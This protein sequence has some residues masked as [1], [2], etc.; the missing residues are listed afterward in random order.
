M[1]YN[2]VFSKSKEVQPVIVE[3]KQPKILNEPV[4]GIEHKIAIIEPVSNTDIVEEF[5]TAIVISNCKLNVRENP[6]KQSSILGVLN[7]GT[8]INVE[9]VKDGWA[10]IHTDSIKGYIM[11]EYIQLQH[12]D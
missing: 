4:V 10:Y 9:Y 12:A 11:V 1:N 8:D 6:N 7:T 5:I 2:K 3:P